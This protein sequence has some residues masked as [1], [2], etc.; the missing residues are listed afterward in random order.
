MGFLDHSTNNI[1]ID[2]VLT[3]EGRAKLASNA[4]AF[5]IDSFSLADDEV[6]YGIIAQYGRTVGKE[7]ITKNTPILE[8]QTSS[9]LALKYPLIMVTDLAALYIPTLTLAGGITVNQQGQSNITFS[10]KTGNKSQTVQVK[11]TIPGTTVIPAGASDSSYTVKVNDR[12]LK[13]GTQPAFNKSDT[14]L[15]ASYYISG[16]PVSNNNSTPSATFELQLK[17]IDDTSFTVFGNGTS[18]VTVVSVIGDQTGLRTDFQV[19]INNG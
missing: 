7:K 19:T 9:N 18:I 1:I 12:F 13:V 6:D 14:T 11:E 4:S 16:T 5:S 10:T 2:A 15:I 3:D 8:A 17:T